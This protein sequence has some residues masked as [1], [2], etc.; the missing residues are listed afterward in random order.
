MKKKKERTELESV[1]GF[2][3]SFYRKFGYTPLII[4]EKPSKNRP[5]L[6]MSLEE[7]ETYFNYFINK[8]PNCRRY[9]LKGK[10]RYREIV[11]Y[12]FMFTHMAR[13][14]EYNLTT[15]GRY[16]NKHHTSIIH[17]QTSFNN[18]M[19]TSENFKE[20]YIEIFNYI[21][22]N[23]KDDKLSIMA[24]TDEAWNQS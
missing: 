4:L 11:D 3:K 15:I 9:N 6:T 24:D 19:E 23:K 8:R 12:R 7:L 2:K 22:T 18:M 5:Y 17:Y 1:Q 20:R 14:M 10:D 13:C 16:L 21:K